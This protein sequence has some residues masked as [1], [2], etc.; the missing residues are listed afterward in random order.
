MIAKLNFDE[1]LLGEPFIQ[2]YYPYYNNGNKT[3][4]LIEKRRL[5]PNDINR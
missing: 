2:R 5:A 1:I 3:I 4:S